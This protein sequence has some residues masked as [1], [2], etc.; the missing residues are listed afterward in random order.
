MFYRY[1]MNSFEE[2]KLHNFIQM[3]SL[4]KQMQSAQKS[5]HIGLNAYR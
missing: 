2:K 4:I 1:S 5:F 3:N